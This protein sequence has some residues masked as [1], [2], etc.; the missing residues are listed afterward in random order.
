MQR[1]IKIRNT[2]QN[3]K[4]KLS[5]RMWIG[6]ILFLCSFFILS[7][8][9]IYD[10][11]LKIEAQSKSASTYYQVFY[12]IGNGFNENDST[13][14]QINRNSQKLH[15]YEVSLPTEKIRQLRIDPGNTTGMVFFKSISFECNLWVF[16]TD[17][18]LFHWFDDDISAK[19]KP[20]NNISRFEANNG[21]LNI[22]SIGNDPYFQY[23]GN[24][25]FK[26]N[27]LTN[28]KYLLHNFR[29]SRYN[30]AYI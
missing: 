24:N 29:I 20:K 19:F 26:E 12:D 17:Y 9:D 22:D 4:F 15:S 1:F 13:T 14:I 3:I 5:L 30:V 6:V 10:I 27:I 11:S 25:F 8:F 2:Y 16:Q 23:G 18:Q 28:K 7:G 21:M